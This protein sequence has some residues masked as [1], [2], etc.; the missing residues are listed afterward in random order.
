MYE[1]LVMIKKSIF[2]PNIHVHLGD[3][4]VLYGMAS[5]N[6]SGFVSFYHHKGVERFGPAPDQEDKGISVGGADCVLSFKD[7]EC[8]DSFI[9]YLQLLKENM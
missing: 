2:K 9:S 3:G 1:G 8:V 4:D 6:G 7:K 5:Q